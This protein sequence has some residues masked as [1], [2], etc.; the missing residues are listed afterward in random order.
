MTSALLDHETRQALYSQAEQ[1]ERTV[2]ERPPHELEP[3]AAD[4]PRSAWVRR[5][6][7][8]VRDLIQTLSPGI[9]DFERGQ[10]GL[11]L[12]ELLVAVDDDSDGID[13]RGE[14]LLATMRLG[15]VV[16][17]IGRRLQHA[18]LE[19]PDEAARYVFEKL[20]SANATDLARLLGVS[21]KTI[22]AWRAGK[23]VRQNAER[24]QLVAQIVSYLAYS[25]T[26]TGVIMWFDNEADLLGG[27]SALDL[28]D[29]S[30]SSAWDRLISYARGGRGQLAD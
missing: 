30:L 8:A 5:V 2:D 29:E 27:R 15:D 1:V 28:M 23:P 26:P 11:F 10:L 12:A 20:P 25:L 21:T 22:G 13:E 9:D 3:S 4:E 17:R 16:R 19:D 18:A 24:V 14:V 7:D 6:V